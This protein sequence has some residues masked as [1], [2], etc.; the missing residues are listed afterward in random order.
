MK[1]QPKNETYRMIGAPLPIQ[2]KDPIKA[3][4]LFNFVVEEPG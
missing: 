2:N 4:T 1:E 3:K